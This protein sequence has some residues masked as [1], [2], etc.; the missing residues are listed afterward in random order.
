M[1]FTW[2]T[3]NTGKFTDSAMSEP[4][5]VV[6]GSYSYYPVLLKSKEIIQTLLKR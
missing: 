1:D 6:N 4:P 5:R 2:L 3:T